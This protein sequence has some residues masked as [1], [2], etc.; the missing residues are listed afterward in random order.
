MSLLLEEHQTD[1]VTTSL[2]PL[3]AQQLNEV[4]DLVRD[5]QDFVLALASD[6]IEALR[7]RGLDGR[8]PTICECTTLGELLVKVAMP[9]VPPTL[10][11]LGLIIQGESNL[12]IVN[13]KTQYKWAVVNVGA[14]ANAAAYHEA[15][16]ATIAVVVAVAVAV[17]GLTFTGTPSPEKGERMQASVLSFS[18]TCDSSSIVAFLDGTGLGRARQQTLLRRAALDGTVMDCKLTEDGYELRTTRYETHGSVL[19]V[20]AL[21]GINEVVIEACS[22]TPALTVA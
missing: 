19:E 22:V 8:I 14:V 21:V 5:D 18:P 6:P 2:A 17:A 10:Q 9:A 20:E 11:S 7:Q 1:T 12:D 3:T 16:A 13:A 4:S 15:G